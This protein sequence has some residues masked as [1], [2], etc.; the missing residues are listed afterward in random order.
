MNFIAP[1]FIA[2][3][4]QHFYEEVLRQKER[5]LRESDHQAVSLFQKTTKLEK[6]DDEGE[7]EEDLASE[8]LEDEAEQD[9]IDIVTSEKNVINI[10]LC[11]NIQRRLRLYIEE[12]ALK[13]PYQLGEYAQ[14]NF[15]EAMYLMTAMADEVFLTLQWPGRTHWKKHLLE[16][17]LFQTQVAGEL[18]FER[19]DALL[20][21]ADPVKHDLA[22]IY[23]LALGLGFRGKYRD[24]DDDGK[25]DWYKKQL[26]H[27]INHRK[28]D[29]YAPG[30]KHIVNAVYEHNVSM[31]VS[32]GLPD[33]RS[34][35]FTILGVAVV[36]LF[37]T[38]ILWYKVVRDIDEALQFIFDQAR[39]LPL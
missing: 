14:S 13:V 30:R 37:V 26:Y 34:W 19:L 27:L 5:A 2:E 1:S 22:V 21:N 25:I 7:S 11:Q 8:I 9:N 31:P 20:E 29:L 10:E 16:T 32:K 36:Y 24:F 15:K 3:T 39:M 38:H 35:V 18:F 33:V 4:F 28:S 6:N 12:Q 23:L 17:Q